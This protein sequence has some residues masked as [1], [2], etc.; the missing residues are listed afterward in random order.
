MV[1][2][3]N[4]FQHF[5]PYFDVIDVDWDQVLTQ[6]LR[7]SLT[8]TST[9]E[10]L[11]TLR[12]LVAQLKDGHG[13]VHHDYDVDA[14]SENSGTQ[15]PIRLARIGD[16]VVVVDKA[17]HASSEENKCPEIGDVVISAGGRPIEQKLQT[18]KR[19]ISGSPQHKDVT[20]LQEFGQGLDRS[21]IPLVLERDGKRVECLVRPSD[22]HTEDLATEPRP[23]PIETFDG[24]VHYVD[25]TRALGPD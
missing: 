6:S 8:D 17:S 15:V 25:L 9:K 7:R 10:F 16:H 23:D 18:A 3:W 13:H 11:Q 4:V 19:Y 2:A 12:R 20:A 21:S 14:P 24:G 1:I 22:V 5:Y